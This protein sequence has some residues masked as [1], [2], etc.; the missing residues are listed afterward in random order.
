MLH[1]HYTCPFHA[2]I[3]IFR[4]TRIDSFSVANILIAQFWFNS[5]LAIYGAT[6]YTD[7]TN[8]KK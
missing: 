5:E 2:S 4:D 6:D 3:V 7:I 1:R 8:S